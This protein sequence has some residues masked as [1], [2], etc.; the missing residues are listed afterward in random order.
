M[1]CVDPK[2]MCS[3]ANTGSV[4]SNEVHGCSATHPS[5]KIHTSKAFETQLDGIPC[6]AAA[7][8]PLTFRVVVPPLLST[9]QV[10]PDLCSGSPIRKTPL[11]AEK[12]LP[13]KEG[14]ALTV[15]AAPW[16]YPSKMKHVFGDDASVVL[17]LLIM[18]AVP[19]DESWLAPAG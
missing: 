1:L 17:I 16:E 4:V 8:R 9:L 2:A 15:A 13:V 10:K 11:T 19:A 12:L 5:P 7:L 14:S 18:S 6:D 3:V